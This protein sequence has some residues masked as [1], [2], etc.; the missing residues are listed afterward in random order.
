MGSRYLEIFC[1]EAEE[2]LASLQSGLLVLERN[3]ERSSLLHE[4]LRNAHTLKGSARMVG[5]SDI[6][7]ITHT[8][9]EQLKGM[10]RGERQVDADAID[11]LLKGADAVALITSALLRGEVPDLDVERFVA[12]YDRGELTRPAPS[13]TRE[14][15]A[16]QQSE[17]VRANVKTLDHLVNLIGEMIINKK[18]LEAKLLTLKEIAASLPADQ[19][20]SLTLFRRDL[21]EDVLYQDYLI[22]ELHEKAMAL[23]MLPLRSISDGFERL[24]RDLAQQLGKEVRLQITGHGIEMDRVLLEGLKPMLIHLLT[25]AVCHGIESPH[26]R[27]AAGKPREGVVSLSARHEGRS[28]IV[29]VADDGKGMDPARI[30]AAALAKGVIDPREAE[31]M[32]DEEALYLTFW[33]GFS[34]AEIVTDISGRGVGMDVVKRNIERVK[35]NI[36]LTSEKGSF[37]RVTLQLPL[38][39]SVIEAL[40]IQCGGEDFAVPLN[41]VQEI[42]KVRPEEISVLGA[43]EVIKV[44]GVTTP[45][46]SLAAMLELPRQTK[47]CATLAVIV[48]KLA[49]QRMACLVD[50]HLGSSEVVVKGLGK[51]F[52]NVRFLFG[53]TIMGDGN[54]ALILNVPDLFSAAANDGRRA[55]RSGAE[56]DEERRFKV[57]VVDDSITTRTMEQSILLTQGYDVVTAVSG[58][59]ALQKCADEDFDLIISDVEMPGINGFELTRALRE[60]ERYREIP[61]IIVSSLSRD[62]DKRQALQSGAQAYIVKGAF[63]QGMLLETVQMLI[64]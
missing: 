57:L 49:D 64:G 31:A 62:E 6:S 25:N 5:L 18:R 38:T 42:L 43:G 23:R 53:A 10:E 13:E 16:E 54:P 37:S 11:L 19:A 2:H 48:L 33:P 24:V 52:R 3:P 47:S 32:G 9:E 26:E 40:L 15:A 8:M 17:T 21:E 22:Q 58:E 61:I 55:T 1:R 36:T 34:T 27:T 44:R 20:Q 50:A 60:S 14:A 30:K 41:Y 28:V 46:Y 7:A 39:L 51:Q 29:E 12:E 56:L 35:G 4:L 45:L 59:D 63:D